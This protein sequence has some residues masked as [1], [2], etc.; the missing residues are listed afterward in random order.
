[1]PSQSSSRSRPGRA[2]ACVLAFVLVACGGGSSTPVNPGPIGVASATPSASPSVAPSTA[3]SSGPVIEACG[4]GPGTL[5]SQ[6]VRGI[7]QLDG[8]VESAIDQLAKDR[9][10]IFDLGDQAGPG[11]YLVKD[12]SAFYDGIVTN[13]AKQGL[14]ANFDYNEIQVKR[15]NDFSEQYDILT[16]NNHVRRAPGSYRST[17][18]PAI[19]PVDPSQFISYVRVAFFGFKCP[20]G[21]TPPG[22]G[23]GTV[24]V[25][26]EGFVTATAKKAD[27]KDVD[28]RLV[29][30]DIIWFLHEGQEQVTPASW[31]GEPFNQYVDAKAP[32]KFMLC[33][34]IRNVQ[35][36]LNGTVTAAP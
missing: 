34:I 14:C 16:S 9:P 11:G 30:N 28:S 7:S 3:P 15:T 29:G 35:G 26:C 31:P 12:A 17:C 33:A 23:A 10:A 27:G 32:G 21:I 4:V 19:F 1:M 20:A 2:A 18:T 22:N 6:C 24:P 36:C 25:G 8:N 13:L 5:D